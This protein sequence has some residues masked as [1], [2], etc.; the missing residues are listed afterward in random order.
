MLLLIILVASDVVAII[1]TSALVAVMAVV[2]WA[3]FEWSMPGMVLASML[4][5][6][7][8][9]F[10]GLHRKV[11]R[12]DAIVMV[13][14][15]LITV[16]VDLFTATLV[17]IGISAVSFS[18][19]QAKEVSIV[20]RLV[21]LE[22]GD[23]E[24]VEAHEQAVKAAN[25]AKASIAGKRKAAKGRAATEYSAAPAS[26]DAKAIAD[27]HPQSREA[28]ALAAATGQ[29]QS[30][31]AGDS[32][33]EESKAEAIA[34]ADID[35]AAAT[36]DGDGALGLAHSDSTVH[37]V[38]A[39]AAAAAGAVPAGGGTDED[40]AAGVIIEVGT[41]QAIAAIA[42]SKEATTIAGDRG[43]APPQKRVYFVSGCVF[44]ASSMDFV[45]YFTPQT[46][47]GD[48]TLVEF[49]FEDAAI[50]DHSGMHALGVIASKYARVGKKVVVKRLGRKCF[51]LV[52]KAND[53]IEHFEYERE[54]VADDD[55]LSGIQL[56]S[57]P[58]FLVSDGPVEAA[59]PMHIQ[60]S[61]PRLRA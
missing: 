12:V 45:K 27:V 40:G 28:R 52:E 6:Q 60:A 51:K 56:R 55:S 37:L 53:L 21:P 48:P 43:E 10:V 17:G 7:A 2:C 54:E 5:K 44:F 46:I 22:A 13:V 34:D 9:T 26:C 59:V 42:E 38:S 36:D 41:A 58:S 14:V 23:F 18:W 49:R 20:S 32:K 30:D 35:A 29:S 8:R 57:R 19:E 15:T 33:A 24:K 47:K 16:F 50:G 3:T 1:P 61:Q 11:R 25:A 39:P 4:P 31:A